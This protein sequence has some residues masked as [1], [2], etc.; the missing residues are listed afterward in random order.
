MLLWSEH[1]YFSKHQKR[2][3]DVIGVNATWTKI[4]QFT[5]LNFYWIC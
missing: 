1:K 3:W 5:A 4:Y 2:S